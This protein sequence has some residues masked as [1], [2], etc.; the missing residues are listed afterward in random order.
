[1]ERLDTI[2]SIIGAICIIS[3]TLLMMGLIRPSFAVWWT[4][5]K[6][7]IKVLF[8]WGTLTTL[9]A[10]AYFIYGGLGKNDPV[11]DESRTQTYRIEYKIDQVA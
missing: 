2:S 7:R 3:G 1:M 9:S 8:V 10:V 11:K 4:A 6:T 5:D